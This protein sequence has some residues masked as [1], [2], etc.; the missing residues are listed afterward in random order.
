MKRFVGFS[1]ALDL[2]LAAIACK[3]AEKL[4]LSQLTGRIL[5]ENIDATVDC[6]SLNTSRKDGFAV[7]SEDLHTATPQN[8]VELTLVGSLCAGDLPGLVLKTGQAIK[9][10][11]GAPIPESAGSVIS[12]E[13]CQ[14]QSM[15][16][17]C[18]NTAETG[19]NIL[20]RGTDVKTGDRIAAVGDR[21]SPAMIGL[22]AAAGAAGATVYKPPRATVI[23]SGD[24]VIAPGNPLPEGKLYASNMVELCA[25]LSA[26]GIPF[27]FEIV[28]DK[29]EDIRRAI[30]RHLPDTDIFITSGG[31]WGSEKDLIIKVVDSL[32]WEGIYHRVRMG[33]GKPVGFGLL[34]NKPFFVLP[35]GPPSNEMAFLQLALPVIMKMTGDNSSVFPLIPACLGEAVS[36]DK[37][38]TQFIHARLEKRENQ[39]YVF[40]FKLRSRLQSMARKDAII[41]IPEGRKAFKVGEIIDVQ[42]MNTF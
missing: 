29:K 40:P 14:Q 20:K 19:K 11:T 41:T 28:A 1:E 25:W 42:I 38:W 23:A 30:E 9:V 32:N 22:M 26:Y 6:P 17:I 34:Q 33:P 5:A 39:L 27:A 13:F 10:T 37:D 18:S 7:I 31:A 8:P 15:S 36:G 3:D 2:S 12:E 21:V 16:I 4:P 35:G 24:E